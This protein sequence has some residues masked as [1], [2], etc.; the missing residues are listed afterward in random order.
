M[1]L[2]VHIVLL[3][4]LIDPTCSIVLERQPPERDIMERPPRDP[5][6]NIVNKRGFIRNLMQGI[7]LFLGA[8]LPYWLVWKQCG[9]AALARTFGVTVLLLANIVLVFT[10][11]SFTDMAARSIARM[12]RDKVVLIASG[13]TVTAALLFAFTPVGR[14]L[15]QMTTLTVP[16]FLLKHLKQR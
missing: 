7:M 16:Q 14:L 5:N 11:A 13:A 9:D 15:L 3:E 2:P 4:L 12:I 10:G 8:F 1:L 6:E